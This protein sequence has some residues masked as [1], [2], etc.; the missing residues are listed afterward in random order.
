MSLKTIR[1]NPLVLT[2]DYNL[3]H[4]MLKCNTDWEVSHIYNREYPM[5]LYGFNEVVIDALN[6]TVTLDMIKEADGLARAKGEHFPVSMFLDLLYKTGGKIPLIVEALPDGTWVP[7]GTPFAQIRNSIEGFG[8]LV[9]WWEALLFQG[10]RFASQCATRALEMRL[11]L[12]EMRKKYNYD[13]SFLYRFHSFGF[14]SHKSLEDAYWAGT[15]WNLFLKGSDDFHSIKHTQLLGPMS[16]S[17]LAHKVVQQYDNEVDCY[18]HA[19]D[20]VKAAGEKIVALVIDTYSAN[21]FIKNFAVKLATYAKN[22]GITVVFRPDSYDQEAGD[23]FHQTWL[24]YRKLCHQNSFI[25]GKEVASIIGED[26]SFDLAKKYD[27]SFIDND[28]PLNFV[29][30]GI[31]EGFHA[32]LTRKM[33]GWS[34]KTAYSNGKPRMKFAEG[35]QSIPGV[36]K[37]VEDY[38]LEPY[39]TKSMECLLQEEYEKK[40]L[41][42]KS[43]YYTPYMY[44]SMHK[45]PVI[46]NPMTWTQIK[47]NADKLLYDGVH[48]QKDIILSKGITD[49]T[50]ELRKQ[51]RGY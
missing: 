31:G 51:Y 35:K 38:Q 16:I 40:T 48:F 5:V 36:V 8:E 30:Y 43:L 22:S 26:M 45:D 47:A 20:S 49:L 23:C 27:T 4:Q 24:L 28:V 19:I 15:A 2:D 13:E 25:A 7:A 46:I 42:P 50:E 33:A 12:E 1:S 11:Y 3:S 17:A 6:I 41:V 44:N 9:T 10:D 14:R 32:D 34:M 18:F 39:G 37:L 21:N 29:S